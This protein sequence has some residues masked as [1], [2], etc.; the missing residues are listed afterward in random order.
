MTLAV[1]SQDESVVHHWLDRWLEFSVFSRVTGV[2]PVDLSGR[3]T[4]SFA[5]EGVAALPPPG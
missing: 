3:W 2:G 5:T 4:V 1:L